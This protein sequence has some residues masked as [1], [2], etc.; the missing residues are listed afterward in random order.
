[1][2][3]DTPMLSDLQHLQEFYVT[4][5]HPCDYL[6]D[7]TA[8]M[9]F[10]PPDIDLSTTA[11]TDLVSR[12]FRRSGNLVY[13]PHCGTCSSCVPIRIPVEGFRPNRSQKRC[14]RKNQD[15][16]VIPQP[17]AFR[18]EH[19]DLYKRYLH[20]RHAGGTM[21]DSTEEDYINFLTCNWCETVFYEFRYQRQ[22]LAVAVTDMLETGLSA[23]YTY[24]DPQ[25]QH[26]SLGTFAVLWQIEETARKHRPWLYLGYWIAQC[27][28]MSYKIQ[29]RPAEIYL[30]QK[31]CLLTGS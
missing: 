5:P 31:W 27:P 26:R 8:R 9:L 15:L 29:Y 30:N 19:F 22:L 25:F 12:G 28:K 20:S 18:Q 3:G 7:E 21:V 2:T 6:A 10:L 11:Y 17:A 4:A 16:E 24:F 23:V 1:M 13:R 14:L